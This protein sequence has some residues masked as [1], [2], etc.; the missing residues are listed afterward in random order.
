[1]TPSKRAALLIG[2]FAIEACMSEQ[3]TIKYEA[4]DEANYAAHVHPYVT[5]AC[6][7]LN[8]HGAPGRPL[9]IYSELGLRADD[10][11]RTEPVDG[12]HAPQD[13]TTAELHSNV[14]AFSAVSPLSEGREHFALRKPLQGDIGH[15][16]GKLFDNQDAA[17]YRCLLAWLAPD[18][19]SGID[20]AAA[21]EKALLGLQ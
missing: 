1:M 2:V 3:G 18:Q 5:L 14:L 16:G 8:C 11:L 13:M 7:A 12:E 4:A 19:A 10:K 15:I 6:A 21:C 20:I 9:R 17:G